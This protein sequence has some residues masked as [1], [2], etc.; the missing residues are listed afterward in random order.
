MLEVTGF[1]GSICGQDS[2]GRPAEPEGGGCWLQAGSARDTR[3][4]LWGAFGPKPRCL[5][6]AG[7]W[8]VGRGG[9]AVR[10]GPQ[11]AT[12]PLGSA[13]CPGCL[14]GAPAGRDLLAGPGLP[15]CPPSAAPSISSLG[16]EAPSGPSKASC[17]SAASHV[18]RAWLGGLLLEDRGEGACRQR[19]GAQLC[20]SDLMTTHRLAP[21]LAS[22][23]SLAF[24]H[25]REA[26]R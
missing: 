7:W 8:A 19:S 5:R 21:P 22:Q 1:A 14:P 9:F 25:W 12:G 16:G 3:S 6:A 10:V 26:Q 17:T 20:L 2:Q 4:T 15:T 13:V 18:L 11:G 23:G 24:H